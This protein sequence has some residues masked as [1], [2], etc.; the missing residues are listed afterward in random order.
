[1]A[2]G[3]LSLSAGVTASQLVPSSPWEQAPGLG[4]RLKEVLDGHSPVDHPL[5]VFCILESLLLVVWSAPKPAS[6]EHCCCHPYRLALPLAGVITE[7]PELEG[8]HKD[9]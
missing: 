7:Y 5:E 2:G 4:W 1:M 9:H 8:P 6:C 3:G